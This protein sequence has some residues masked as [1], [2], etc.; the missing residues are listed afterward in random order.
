MESKVARQKHL[1]G[2]VIIVDA[3]PKSASGKI[4]R[5][6]LRERAKKEPVDSKL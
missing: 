1:R 4:L 3:I 2:G 5:K 6:E